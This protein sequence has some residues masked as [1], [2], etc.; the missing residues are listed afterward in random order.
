MSDSLAD[1][2]YDQ[3]VA[4]VLH[5]GAVKVDGS[6]QPADAT[7]GLS[8]HELGG[9]ADKARV[10]VDDRKAMIKVRIRPK[11]KV[12]A[13]A[14]FGGDSRAKWK[15]E[16]QEG[17]GKGEGSGIPS[18]HPPTTNQFK[19]KKEKAAYTSRDPRENARHDSYDLE[20]SFAPPRWPPRPTCESLPSNYVSEDMPMPLNIGIRRSVEPTNG[21]LVSDPIKDFTIQES[22]E[23]QQAVHHSESSDKCAH[24]QNQPSSEDEQTSGIQRH[25]ET[26]APIH[27]RRSVDSH[28]SV[29]LRPQT[30]SSDHAQHHEDPDSASLENEYVE[31]APM[32][33]GRSQDI[34][35]RT[36]G[37][38][39]VRF[40]SPVFR[41]L[42]PIPTSTPFEETVSFDNALPSRSPHVGFASSDSNSLPLFPTPTLFEET[43]STNRVLSSIPRPLPPLPRQGTSTPT[44]TSE[45]HTGFHPPS[46]HLPSLPPSP[47]NPRKSYSEPLITTPSTSSATRDPPW[48]TYA[49]LEQQQKERRKLREQDTRL[50]R[51]FE[52]DAR[53]REREKVVRE[54]GVKDGVLRTEA[55]ELRDLI[56]EVYPEMEFERRGME[57]ERVHCCCVM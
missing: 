55:M 42:P 7:K 9:R 49:T 41:P 15:K 27:A 29:D 28:H 57:R 26:Y 56:R 20:V 8:Q 34:A 46:P 6:C 31:S 54:K 52:A 38:P 18:I 23:D 3:T 19:Q 33:K 11:Y 10:G 16:A 22:P 4:W 13:P 35:E 32:D 17:K 24:P 40:A 14:P 36:S 39:H 48:G 37:S 50:A 30:S 21:P 25:I 12:S 43:A 53:R 5:D 44:P 51:Q 1:D 2:K 45:P 47:R